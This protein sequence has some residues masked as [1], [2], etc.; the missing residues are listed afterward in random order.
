MFKRPKYN[1]GEKVE[2]YFDNGEEQVKMFGKIVIV[3]A[4]GV[5]SQDEPSYDVA[6]EDSGGKKLYKHV[7]ESSIITR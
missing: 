4:C 2:F 3:D 5:E 1:Y 6:I 7:K